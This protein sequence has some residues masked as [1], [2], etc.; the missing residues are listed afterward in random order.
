MTVRDGKKPSAKE[1]TKRS[2]NVTSALP[3]SV[4]DIPKAQQSFVWYLLPGQCHVLIDLCKWLLDDTC[5]IDLSPWYGFQNR[6]LYRVKHRKTKFYVLQ[7]MFIWDKVSWRATA[8]GPFATPSLPPLKK[9]KDVP[10]NPK[11]YS[12]HQ[13]AWQGTCINVKNYYTMDWTGL[14]LACNRGPCGGI[15]LKR[16]I[17][18]VF[19]NAPLISLS[20]TLVPILHREY[21][22]ASLLFSCFRDHVV[23]LTIASSSWNWLDFLPRQL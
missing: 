1:A 22:Y 5:T 11:L 20:Y 2:V 15:W 19:E 12:C 9:R 16:E 7:Y 14:G 6:N 17:P 8:G 23:I 10:F 18:F 4:K 13:S 3:T 21:E